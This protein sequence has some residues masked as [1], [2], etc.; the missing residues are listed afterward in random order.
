MQGT[1]VEERSESQP[2]DTPVQRLT[3]ISRFDDA[4]YERWSEKIGK[5]E[6]KYPY[7]GKR[8]SG[9]N[10]QNFR[11]GSAQYLLALVGA[12]AKIFDYFHRAVIAHGKAVVATQHD[13]INANL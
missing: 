7:S 1:Q 11:S 4:E 5:C 8:T 2:T 9:S 13:S 3:P 10:L 6:L 12:Q